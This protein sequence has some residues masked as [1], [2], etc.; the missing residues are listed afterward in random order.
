[1]TRISAFATLIDDAIATLVANGS[2]ALRV[3]RHAIARYIAE[4]LEVLYGRRSRT[5]IVW[6]ELLVADWPR[7]VDEATRMSMADEIALVVASGTEQHVVEIL[8]HL[9]SLDRTSDHTEAET[10][11]LAKV[12]FAQSGDDS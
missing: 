11:A 8:K 12:L 10:L 4:R 9:A 3:E 7:G 5:L 6:E 1:M 2:M